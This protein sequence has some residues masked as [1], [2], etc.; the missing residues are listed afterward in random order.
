VEGPGGL[1]Y[2]TGFNGGN[3]HRN[4]VIFTVDANG[5]YNVIHTFD[6]FNGGGRMA[7]WFRQ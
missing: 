4:G 3:S 5:D 1:F 2:G 6:F 7:G